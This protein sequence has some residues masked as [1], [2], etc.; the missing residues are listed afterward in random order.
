MELGTFGAVLKYALDLEARASTF[1]DEA[2]FVTGNQDLKALYEALLIGGQKRVGTLL[3]VRRE[4]IT[5]MILEPISGLQSDNFSPR[6]ILPSEKTDDIVRKM[7]EDMETVIAAFYR[8]AANKIE[9]LAE[10][11]DIFERL[12]EDNDENIQRLQSH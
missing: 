4:N 5:E 7:A 6:V 11:A 3:R 8:T 9:F 12:A 1:Y 10:A 2:S